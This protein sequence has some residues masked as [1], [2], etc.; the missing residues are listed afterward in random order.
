[1]KTEEWSRC[2]EGF[3]GIQGEAKTKNVAQSSKKQ[4]FMDIAFGKF[5]T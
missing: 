3:D 4:L 1:M 5:Q 2:M